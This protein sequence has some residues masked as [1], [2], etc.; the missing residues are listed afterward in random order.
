MNPAPV[1]IAQISDLHVKRLGEKAYGI[2]DTAT[3]LKRCV[4]QINDLQPRPAIVVASGDLVDTGAEEEYAHLR[5]LLR[6]LEIPLAVLPGN[7]DARDAMR[8]AFPNQA[9]AS[10]DGPANACIALGSLDLFLIDSTV[11]GAP[12]GALDDATLSWLDGG[13]HA[14]DRRPAILF[15]HH[16]PFKS[17]IWHMDRQ[18]L[19]NAGAM[20]EI[21]RRHARVQMVSAGHVHRAV[22][23]QFAGVPAT[24]CPAPNHAVDLDLGQAREPSFK[25]EP[26]AFHLHAWFGEGELG[27]LVTHFVAI[28]EFAGPHPFFGAD[29]KLL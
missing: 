29:G 22:V 9:Y 21:V 17:G 23:T 2:V 26:A 16:P 18:N 27:C 4:A 7:H 6:P 3:A 24:I 1:L 8:R 15:L 11:P 5:D 10:L 12:H 13:L 14:N 25:L 19:T 20:A 28:G